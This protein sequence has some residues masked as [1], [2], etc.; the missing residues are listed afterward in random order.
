M[1]NQCPVCKS[2]LIPDNGQYPPKT[3]DRSYFDCSRCGNYFIPRSL[4]VGLA[5]ILDGNVEKISILSYSIRKMQRNDEIP[6]VDSY[7]IEQLLQNPPPTLTEQI[8][9]YI[10][11]L[12]GR[13]TPGT[14]EVVKT[15]TQLSVMGALT[16]EGFGLV[17]KRL[18]A[19]G[20]IE[21]NIQLDING[22][23]MLGKATLTFDGWD[24]LDKLNR[25]SVISRKAFMA[26][27]FGDANLDMMFGK[28]LKPA[29]SVTGFELYRL[30]EV[31]RAGL[32]DDRLR[33]EIRTSRF[34]I[35]DLT[36]ENAG[37]YWEAGYAEGLGKPVIYTCEK[38][39]FDKDKT[40]FDTNHH[41][42]VVWD[43]DY[44]ELAVEQLKAIIRAT[45][46]DEAKLTDA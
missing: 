4:Q 8:N 24:Y 16:A 28:Y 43:K 45:L 42:T 19:K 32:I 3:G 12:G 35:S 20:L 13:T 21:N 34:L 26:M 36:H 39:K 37:A 1:A 2:D 31:P 6:Y 23:V 33:V 25:G 40:H 22:R 11:W 44:P 14:S 30:D 9:N 41:L 5:Q 17:I 27:K 38:I 7:L 18:M 29:V 10:L 46:P 15:S